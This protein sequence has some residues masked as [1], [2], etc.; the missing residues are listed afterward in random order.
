MTTHTLVFRIAQVATE[1]PETPATWIVHRLTGQ[2]EWRRVAAAPSFDTALVA[3]FDA[4]PWTDATTFSHTDIAPD[5]F[6][7]TFQVQP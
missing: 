4:V 5:I 2:E 3:L 6:E 1:T 7:F